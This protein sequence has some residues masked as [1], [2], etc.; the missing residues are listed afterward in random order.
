MPGIWDAIKS[1]ILGQP[2]QANPMVQNLAQAGFPGAQQMMQQSQPR[3]GGLFG[4]GGALQQPGSLME[5]LSVPLSILGAVENARGKPVGGAYLGGIG[6]V[7][8]QLGQYKSGQATATNTAEALKKQI[9]AQFP[10]FAKD[11]GLQEATEEIISADPTAGIKNLESL[12]KYFEGLNKPKEATPGLLNAASMVA[13]GGIPFDKLSTDKQRQAAV[14]MYQKMQTDPKFQIMQK[15]QQN[16][17]DRMDKA[18]AN[19]LAMM[20]QSQAAADARLTRMINARE[21]IRDAKDAKERVAAQKKLAKEMDTQTL[22]L[23]REG[24]T[25]MAKSKDPKFPQDQLQALVESYNN[26]VQSLD[27]RLAMSA[28]DLPAGWKRPA[29]SKL[30][31]APTPGGSYLHWIPLIGSKFPVHGTVS[32]GT[33][34]TSGDID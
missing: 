24:R 33:A 4:A 31:V 28:E 27:D 15:Q 3:Q 25:I 18:E 14:A 34:P 16:A 7:L 17:L 26:S 13:N 9:A 1:L 10:Q 30:Q 29:L 2:Q 21:D 32:A 8:G 11:K 23:S 5:T 19:R 22:Q 6:D 12:Q 20:M